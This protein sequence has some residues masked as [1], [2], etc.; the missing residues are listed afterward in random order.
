MLAGCDYTEAH[1][2]AKS[3]GLI[4]GKTYFTSHVDLE[5][6]LQRL[7]VHGLGRKRFTSMR[8]VQ[9]P[10]IVKVNSRDRYWHWVVLTTR[11]GRGVLLDPNPQRPGRIVDFRGYRGSG[12]Y[13]FKHI[14]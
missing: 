7:G 5:K 4:R 2:K 6:L 11:A 10:A 14:S 12:N 13:I 3:L 1:K 9:T 8:S